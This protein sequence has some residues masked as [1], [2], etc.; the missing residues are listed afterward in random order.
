MLKHPKKAVDRWYGNEPM[1]LHGGRI[2]QISYTF[3]VESSEITE[4]QKALFVEVFSKYNLLLPIISR[5]ILDSNP[6]LVSF[7][8]FTQRIGSRILFYAPGFVNSE[9]YDFMLGYEENENECIT[10]TYFF[11]FRNWNLEYF[12]I[13]S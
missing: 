5:K 1:L 4:S 8:W 12:E 11:G 10:S 3:R 2:N 13:F 9:V 7:E 6:A